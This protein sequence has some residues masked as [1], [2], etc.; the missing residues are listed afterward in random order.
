MRDQHVIS[1]RRP[2]SAP[3]SRPPRKRSAWPWILPSI[4][5]TFAVV[6]AAAYFIVSKLSPAGDN[7]EVE[8]LVGDVGLLMLLPSDEQPTVATVTNLGALRDQPFFKSAKIG[9]K[10]LMYPKS[11]RAILYSPSE[12]M[13]I[14]VAPITLDAE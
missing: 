8:E 2:F 6:L 4:I 7:E 9:D 1:L 10:V 11:G 13:I 3:P 5:V 12:N 14:E